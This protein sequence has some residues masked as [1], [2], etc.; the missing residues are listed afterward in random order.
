MQVATAQGVDRQ[1]LLRDAGIDQNA[2]VLPGQ[3]M[4]V[5]DFFTLYKLAE[6][7][8]GNPDL[9]LEV[10]RVIYFLGL[11]L[12][13]Y[14]TT[15]C[16]NLREY[17]NVI[18]SALN[19]RGDLGTVSMQSEGEFVRL[20][21]H[22]LDPGTRSWRCLSDE[23]LVAS[24]LIVDSICSLPVP[25]LAAQFSYPR[26]ASVEKL[27]TLFGPDLRFDCEVSCLYFERASLRYPLIALDY[28]LGMEFSAAPQSLFESP[29]PFLRDIRTAMRRVLPSGGLTIDSLSRDMNISRRTLQRRLTAH[30]S[31]FKQ[32]LQELRMELADRYLADSRLGITEIAFL[33]GYS[34]QAS[35]SNAFK[36]WRGCSPSDYRSHR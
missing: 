15:I 11:N 10:G 18:P 22:P 24:A 7:R 13:L 5:S 35:F 31:S 29:S 36:L 6:Q 30:D 17:L 20:D 19:L 32:L 23:M 16:R 27:E 26:P 28:D 9:G 14:M 8:T 12:Q 21:W 34:D 33:L 3:R 4:L 2:L 25:V 1:T